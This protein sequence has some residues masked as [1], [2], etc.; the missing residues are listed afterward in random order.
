MISERSGG[1]SLG[2]K[3]RELEP[4]RLLIPQRTAEC[5]SASHIIRGQFDR[6][7]AFARADAADADPLVLKGLHDAVETP[8]LLAKQIF[9]G[10]L[11]VLKTDLGGI[12]TEP[13]VLVEFGDRYAGCRA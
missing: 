13:A 4:H 6:L 10:N 9:Q 7:G 5:L 8:V 11:D 3:H 2:G 12:G 1:G